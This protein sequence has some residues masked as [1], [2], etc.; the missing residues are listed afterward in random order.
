MP[1]HFLDVLL[2]SPA[3]EATGEW[4]IRLAFRHAAQ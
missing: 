4:L 3:Y 1:A 2:E